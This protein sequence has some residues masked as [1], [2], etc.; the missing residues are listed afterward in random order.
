VLH[1]HVQGLHDRVREYQEKAAVLAT[2]KGDVDKHQD[3]AKVLEAE[4]KTAFED[5][6]LQKSVWQK[7]KE[8]ES[9]LDKEVVAI[10]D[11]RKRVKSLAVSFVTLLRKRGAFVACVLCLRKELEG[12]NCNCLDL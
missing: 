7:L 1:C 5:F 4:R 11:E 3:D 6:Q 12:E 10:M 2:T 9:S 8:E